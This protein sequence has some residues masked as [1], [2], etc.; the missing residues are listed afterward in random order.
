MRFVTSLA[1][2]AVAVAACGRAPQL[3]TR[4]FPLKH[5][6]PGTAQGIIEPYV[7]GDRE[8]SPGM[9]SVTENTLTVRET[10]DNLEKIAR[11]LA[12][13][14]VPSPWVRLHFQLIEADGNR[15]ADPRIADIETELRKLFRYEGY[16]L[17]AEAVVTGTARSSVQQSIGGNVRQGEGFALAVQIGEIRVIGE[18][19]YVA[20]NVNLQSPYGTGLGT[21]VNARTGQTLVIG[22]AKLR[23]GSGTMILAVRPELAEK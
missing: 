23:E 13:F 22:N 20:L 10:P 9:M 4:T 12:E 2:A 11:V 14:D 21:R 8:G 7:F 3:E 6:E 18:S 16:R 17:A 19:G 1:L 15:T 5:I